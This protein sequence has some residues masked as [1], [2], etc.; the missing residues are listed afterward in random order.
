VAD[1]PD[2]AVPPPEQPT[3]EA[4][5]AL[6]T[7]AMRIGLIDVRKQVVAIE[8]EARAA[9]RRAVARIVESFRYSRPLS[10]G[11]PEHRMWERNEETIRAILDAVATDTSEE[12]ER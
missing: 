3:S 8:A 12:P 10:P 5:R 7:N 11:N 9:E 4:G 2:R 1:L 6:V